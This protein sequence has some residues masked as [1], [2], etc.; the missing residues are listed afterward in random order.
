MFKKSLLAAAVGVLM[1]ASAAQAAVIFSDN[2]D[3]EAPLSLNYTGF[4]NWTVTSGSVDLI[5]PGFFDFYPGHGNYVDM[6]GSTPGLTPASQMTSNLVFGPGAYTLSF[7]LGGSQ[8]GDTNTVQAT[9]GDF[10]S[11]IVLPSANPLTLFSFSFTTSVAG[12]LVFS[13]PN[14]A[15]NFGLILDDVTLSDRALA[16]PEPLTFSL[17]GAGLAGVAAL[18]R[19]KKVRPA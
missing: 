17:F 12:N 2:F 4:A 7:L 15:N 18:R 1:S 11:A 10:S 5:G 13:D 16:V 19:R 3:A 9:L 6:D 8:R 14:T